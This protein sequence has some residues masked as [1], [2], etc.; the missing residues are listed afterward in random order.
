MILID[1]IDDDQEDDDHI[2]KINND[3]NNIIIIITNSIQ[4]SKGNCKHQRQ[5]ANYKMAFQIKD[6]K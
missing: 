6:N 4:K 5:D 2:Y 1:Y 3:N